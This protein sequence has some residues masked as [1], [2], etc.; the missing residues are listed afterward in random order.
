MQIRNNQKNDRGLT[1]NFKNHKFAILHHNVQSLL[2][3][4]MKLTV[5]LN[6]SLQGID[7]L[8]FTEHWLSEDQI[9]LLEINNFK[10]VS[11]FCRKDC[12]NGGSC[13]F[14][15]KELNIMEITFLNDLYCEKTEKY[16]E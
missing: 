10:L 16:L 9:V 15:N 13:I 5:L 4:Q 7:V 14:I 2:N 11:K 6:T 8:C 3:K 1:L 12:K